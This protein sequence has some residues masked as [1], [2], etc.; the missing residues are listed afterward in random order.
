MSLQIKQVIYIVQIN[1]EKKSKSTFSSKNRCHKILPLKS[2]FCECFHNVA[3]STS[4]QFTIPVLW[5]ILHRKR[6]LIGYLYE[7]R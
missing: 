4:R 2:L 6:N 7:S 5:L 3:L 1:R